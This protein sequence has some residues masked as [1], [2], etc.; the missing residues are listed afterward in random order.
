MLANIITLSR[1]LLTFLVIA[2][3][4]HHPPLNIALIFAIISQV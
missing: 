2:P 1:V 3:F 4:G